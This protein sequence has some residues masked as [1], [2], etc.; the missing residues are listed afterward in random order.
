[1]LVQGVFFMCRQFELWGWILISLGIGLLLGT[2]LE[3]GFVQLC[4]AVGAIAA[5]IMVM[6]RK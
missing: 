4:I 6:Q 1:M 3:S 5:G 2:F